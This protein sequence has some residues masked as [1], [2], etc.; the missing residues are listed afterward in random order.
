M[1]RDFQHQCETNNWDTCFLSNLLQE[2]KS[3]EHTLL[4]TRGQECEIC[5]EHRVHLKITGIIEDHDFVEN[6]NHDSDILRKNRTIKSKQFIDKSQA[7]GVQGCKDCSKWEHHQGQ[8][9]KQYI[10][11]REAYKADKEKGEANSNG[12]ELSLSA[13]M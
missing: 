9:H 3:K 12:N 10:E 5:Q 8:H 7:C 2:N 1:F 13:D 11:E 4:Q 6:D